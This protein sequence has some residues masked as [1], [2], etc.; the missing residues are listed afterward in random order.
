M[1]P[2]LAVHGLMLSAAPPA[3]WASRRRPKWD[4]AAGEPGGEPAGGDELAVAAE[5]DESARIENEDG[6][7]AKRNDE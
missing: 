6:N 5:L 1:K 2:S 4:G 7:T 3:R